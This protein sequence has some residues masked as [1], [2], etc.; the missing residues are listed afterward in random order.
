MGETK[1]LL[2]MSDGIK[3]VKMEYVLNICEHCTRNSVF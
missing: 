3:W 1:R 2:G